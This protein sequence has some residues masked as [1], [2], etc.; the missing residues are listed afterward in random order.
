MYL[1]DGTGKLTIQNSFPAYKF[2]TGT[3]QAIDANGD[4]KLDLFVGARLI[5][6][7]YP[8]IP[9]SKLLINDGS[10]NFA[11]ETSTYL[12]NSGKLGLITSSELIDMNDDGKLDLIL[13]GEFMPITVMINTGNG[14]KNQSTTYLSSE[15]S[16]WWNRVS[17]A[18]IDGD[19]DMDL[20]A[21]NFGLNSQFEANESKKLRLYAADFDQNGSIDPI[22]ECFVGD[23]MYPYP[24]RDELLD[25]MASMRSR[26]TDYA[27]YSKATMT[28]L[29]TVKELEKAQVLEANTLESVVLE[30][31]GNGFTAKSLP[32]LAQSFPIFSILPI[33]LNQDGN[34]DLI[35][36][37]NQ[38]YTRIRIG[39]MDAGLGLVL[40]GDGKGNFQPLSPAESGLAIK[41]DI[42]SI[43]PIK[44]SSG[45]QLLFGI[46]QKPIE[47][48]TIR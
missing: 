34:M 5:P 46:N 15:L 17:K 21:G 45:I 10:G 9:E 13:A 6:G 4:G 2:S 38:T 36:G 42:K 26:F 31:T 16:G 43:L 29:F 23:K 40:L 25:Q 14:F 39:L 19:G 27:S 3:A 8:I 48:Y 18:D 37:G 12:P 1:N 44:T 20:I 33:D 32:R 35:L 28:D 41:G 7:K 22:L 47:S 30:N 24:S 11:D